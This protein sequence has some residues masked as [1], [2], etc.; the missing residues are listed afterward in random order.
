MDDFDKVKKKIGLALKV[1]A[2]VCHSDYEKATMAQA[3][4]ADIHLILFGKPPKGFTSTGNRKKGVMD[5]H[6]IVSTK[7]PR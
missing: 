7:K 6:Y 3:T 4:F 5:G 1:M 2:S